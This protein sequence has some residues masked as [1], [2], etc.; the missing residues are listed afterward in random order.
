VL[1]RKLGGSGLKVSLLSFGSWV[2]FSNQVNQEDADGLIK[3]AFDS[4]VNFFDNAEAYANGEAE[5]I[6]GRSLKKLNISR[7]SY[8][9][10]SKVYFGGEL[11]TQ[12]GL[13]R[14]HIYDACHA[15]LKRMQLD[16]LD[17]FFCHRPDYDTPIKETVWAMNDLI[18]Q[19]KVMYWGTSEWNAQQITEAFQVADKYNLIPPTMEQPQ[20]NMFERHRVEIEYRELYKNFGLGT[21]IWSPLASG[22]LSG[23]YGKKIPKDSRLNVPGYEWLKNDF[24]FNEGEKIKKVESLKRIANELGC[25]MACLSIA[26]CAVNEDVSSVILGASNERQLKENIKSIDVIDKL[27]NEILSRI[28]KIIDNKPAVPRKY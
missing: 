9:I 27:D 18:R 5:I 11:P 16:Y 6:M 15:A 21:T 22:L 23:K 10:S 28:D 17:M 7:D 14:K 24:Y 4:G 13:S 2:T 1:Y 20:Y 26:W 25:S 3:T 12:R 19:G 8:C